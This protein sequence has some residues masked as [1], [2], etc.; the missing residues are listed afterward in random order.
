MSGVFVRDRRRITSQHA[1]TQNVREV[2]QRVGSD[3]TELRAY[4]RFFGIDWPPPEDLTFDHHWINAREGTGLFTSDQV[5]HRGG[6][7]DDPLR[8]RDFAYPEGAQPSQQ[9]T[10]HS[11]AGEP[12]R[13]YTDSQYQGSQSVGRDSRNDQSFD[14]SSIHGQPSVGQSSNDRSSY[15]QSHNGPDTN[16]QSSNNRSSA[17]PSYSTQPEP[18]QTNY[19]QQSS[20][21]YSNGQSHGGEASDDHSY[22]DG[23]A[24]NNQSFNTQSSGQQES[25][26]TVGPTQ[27]AVPYEEQ[28]PRQIDQSTQP[29]PLSPFKQCL[30]SCCNVM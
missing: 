2:Y 18:S 30:C 16:D 3:H 19:G 21:R 14:G 25:I 12:S 24:S 13:T 15:S 26:S 5:R 8:T 7:D 23:N 20:N 4:C 17:V 11:E 1:L 22:N 27:P 28:P 10:T 6:S 9:D 29:P